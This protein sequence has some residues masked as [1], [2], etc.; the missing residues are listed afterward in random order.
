MNS[1]DPDEVTQL[2]RRG[3]GV[4]APGAH[5]DDGPAVDVKA[6]QDA[7]RRDERKN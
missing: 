2:A 1:Q 7:R 4:F 3:L 5:V 6:V